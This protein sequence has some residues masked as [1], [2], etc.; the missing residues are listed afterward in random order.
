MSFSGMRVDSVAVNGDKGVVNLWFRGR[1]I[2]DAII[3]DLKLTQGF[4]S[5]IKVLLTGCSAGGLS[6]FFQADYISTI[7]PKSVTKYGVAPGSGF[8][9]D[10]DNL[11]GR[12]VYGVQMAT[13]FALAN[14]SFGVNQDCVANQTRGEEWK[15]AF[16]EHSIRYTQSPIFVVNTAY[17][18]WQFGCILTSVPVPENSTQN[19]ICYALWRPCSYNPSSCSSHEIDFFN[20]NART[21]LTRYAENPASKKRGNGCFVHSCSG[22]CENWF[23]RSDKGDTTMREAFLSWW[24]SDFKEDSGLHTHLPCFWNTNQPY[25]CNPTCPVKTTDTLDETLWSDSLEYNFKIEF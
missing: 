21:F 19:G 5:A 24:D 6:A 25:N 8:F 10:H 2:V 18:S 3:E 11:F 13:I 23:T 7:L 20:N 14:A 15:C 16:A 9:L 17:D 22:H 12:P 4:D 1:Y